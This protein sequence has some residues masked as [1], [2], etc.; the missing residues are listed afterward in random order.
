[1]GVP[2]FVAAGQVRASSVLAALVALPALGLGQLAGYPLRRHLHGE[3]FRRL[4]LVLLV[5]AAL[6]AIARSVF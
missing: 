1:V 2:L 4:V 6:S 5:V 3:R